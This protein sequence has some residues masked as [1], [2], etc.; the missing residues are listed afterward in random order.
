MRRIP[1][2]I[3]LPPLSQRSREERQNLVFTLLKNEQKRIGKT[4][5]VSSQV[6][7]MLANYE[8]TGNIGDLKNAIKL[9]IARANAENKKKRNINYCFIF[10]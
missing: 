9:T 1:V 2:K 4:L 5:N 6:L 7:K 8:P 10:T 3:T